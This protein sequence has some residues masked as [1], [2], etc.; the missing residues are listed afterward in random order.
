M[1]IYDTYHHS[2]GMIEVSLNIK[3]EN[4]FSGAIKS[5]DAYLSNIKSY[6]KCI[7]LEST[8]AK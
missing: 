4:V 3:H 5:N 6:N 8:R 2:Y 1:Y 7:V